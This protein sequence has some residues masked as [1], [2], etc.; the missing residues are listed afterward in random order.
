MAHGE[1][2]ERTGDLTPNQLFET[3]FTEATTD[4]ESALPS[5]LTSQDANLRVLSGELPRLHFPGGRLCLS[6][7][8]LLVDGKRPV[9]IF[10]N[11][12]QAES[13]W[14]GIETLGKL[15]PAH[16]AKISDKI[17][18]R[19]M[20]ALRFIGPWDPKVRREVLQTLGK[21]E[22]AAFAQH[23][24]R[25]VATL[26]D[27]EASVRKAAVATFGKLEAA[28]LLSQE[29]TAALARAREQIHR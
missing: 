18:A 29:H 4:I 8:L 5:F 25:L 27:S 3:L 23:A 22:P 12:S 19:S 24:D 14:R 1:Y 2:D 26:D 7:L 9:P 13:N 16:L 15:D 28:A 17:V 11:E 10:L 20:L 6:T 21:F